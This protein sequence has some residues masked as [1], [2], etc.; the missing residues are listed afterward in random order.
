MS[1]WRSLASISGV[2]F[3][4]FAAVGICILLGWGVQKLA[5]GTAP[6]GI[7]V[8][9]AI[10]FAAAIYVMVVGMRAYVRGEESG[11]GTKR[12]E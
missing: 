6:F 4:V 1:V 3:Q 9:A 10:G 5:P 7:L 11:T 2:A 8:G 12:E